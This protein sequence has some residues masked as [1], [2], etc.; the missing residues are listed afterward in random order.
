MKCVL[1]T[2]FVHVWWCVNVK[3][4]AKLF[5]L[6]HDIW[7][8]TLESQNPTLPSE[9]DTDTISAAVIHISKTRSHHFKKIRL[10]LNAT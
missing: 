6:M 4:V 5:G 9:G 1:C 7:K 8:Q 3:A 2:V 10:M